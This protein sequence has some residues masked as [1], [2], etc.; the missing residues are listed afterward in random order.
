MA[1]A[2]PIAEQDLDILLALAVGVKFEGMSDELGMTR[3]IPKLDWRLNVCCRDGPAGHIEVSEGIRA[4]PNQ[5]Q[6]RDSSLTTG[7][8]LDRSIHWYQ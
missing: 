7:F 4:K 6:S 3:K 2:D 5:K 8:T 1:K